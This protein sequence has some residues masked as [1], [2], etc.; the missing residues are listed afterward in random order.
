MTQGE[1][2]VNMDLHIVLS[3]DYDNCQQLTEMH[4]KWVRVSL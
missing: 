4:I 3:V 2:S 1:L